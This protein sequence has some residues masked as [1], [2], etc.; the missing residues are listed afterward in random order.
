[1]FYSLLEEIKQRRTALLSGIDVEQH[2]QLPDVVIDEVNS[3][4]P[5][6]YFGDVEENNLKG[7]EN[8]LFTLILDDPQMKQKYITIAKD[9]KPGPNRAACLHFL[10][11][12]ESI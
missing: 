5:R 7:Y 4:S 8:L 9:G 2:I 10:N 1:M 11:E 3:S 6:F 12:M